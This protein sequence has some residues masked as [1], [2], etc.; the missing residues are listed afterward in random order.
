MNKGALLYAFDSKVKYTKLA[1]KCAK[2]IKKYLQLE[3][4][5]EIFG[6]VLLQTII[7]IYLGLITL[8][9]KI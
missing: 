5:L 2:R 7:L 8:I 4:Q 1:I 3:N 9:M 6:E